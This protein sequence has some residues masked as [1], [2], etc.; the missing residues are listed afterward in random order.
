MKKLVLIASLLFIAPSKS[1][2]KQVWESTVIYDVPGKG[3]CT[4]F[5]IRFDPPTYVTSSHCLLDEAGVIN[6]SKAV[7]V[8]VKGELA[9]LVVPDGKA[10]PALILGSKPE[11]GD[12]I[13]AFGYGGPESIPF[14]FEGPY[15]GETK[16][17]D[18]DHHLSYFQQNTMKGMS[19]GPIVNSE[20][21]VV[22]VALC[23][24]SYSPTDAQFGCG[25]T[26]NNTADF[27]RQLTA[28]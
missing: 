10:I 18:V 7:V 27:I 13:I 6:G 19:G 3:H 22:S 8:A 15:L 23:G 21:R 20:G 26:Y 5:A 17:H 14:F 24:G 28:R 12:H 25:E 2:Y 1:I 9:G 4:A 11:L 16:F